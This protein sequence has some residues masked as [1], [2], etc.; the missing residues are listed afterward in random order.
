MMMDEIEIGQA[1]KLLASV[2]GRVLC[3]RIVK[4]ICQRIE[5]GDP[6]AASEADSGIN[7]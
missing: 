6:K 4:H 5:G 7:L 2:K 3:Q 1:K